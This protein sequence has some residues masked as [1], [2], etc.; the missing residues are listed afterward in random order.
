MAAGPA[1]AIILQGGIGSGSSNVSLPIANDVAHQGIAAGHAGG[2]LDW[3]MY[4][5]WAGNLAQ[6]HNYSNTVT[7][8]GPGPCFVGCVALGVSP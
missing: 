6:P 1:N 4:L 2:T 8:N 5:C 7:A 3:V